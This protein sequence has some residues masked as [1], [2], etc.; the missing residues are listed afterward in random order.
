MN[1]SKIR[2]ALLCAGITAWPT[3]AWSQAATPAATAATDENVVTLPEFTIT[4]NPDNPYISR[5]ALSASRVAMDIQDI[6]QSV[7]VVT[8]DFL[9]DSMSHRMLDAAK[10][11]TTVVEGTLPIGGDRYNI[12]GFQVSQEFID[13]AQS[14]G[15]DGYSMSLVPY[16][17]E[18]IEI[19]KGPN[20]IL[21]PG[22]SPGGQFNPITKSPV[23]KDQGSVTL[24]LAQYFSNA[25]SV[26]VNRIISTEK[27]VATR[28]VAAYWNSEG[29][30]REHFRRGFMFAPSLAW[31]LSD[32]HKFIAKFEMMRNDEAQIGG[33]PLDPSVG[34]NDY[35]RPAPGLPRNWTFGDGNLDRR[36]RET[37]RLTLELLSTL[38]DHVSSRLQLIGNHVV[39]EDAGGTGAAI[40]GALSG[41]GWG[42]VNP[43]TG[44]WEPG[45][46]WSVNQ[47][48][49]NAVATATPVTI[50]DPST[51]VYQRS[52]GA[53]D[54]YYSEAHLRNDYAVKFEGETWRSTTIGGVAANF[55]KVQFKSYAN[56]TRPNVP[57]TALNNA[58][59]PAYNY[60]QPSLPVRNPVTGVATPNGG[61][62]TGEL[63]DLQLF[64]FESANLFRDRVILSGGL[65][66]YFGRLARTDN[67][68]IGVPGVDP[69]VAAGP[70]YPTYTLSTNAVSWGVV[71][72]PIKHVSLFYG[73]NTSGGAMPGQLNA[74]GH[75]PNF[76]T[77]V[78][79]QKEWGIKTSLLNDRFTA[80]FAHFD[81]AQSNY[82]VPNS[83]YYTLV[84][85]G[86]PVP[87]DFPVTL[88]LNQVSKG[89]EAEFTYAFNNNFTILGNV[90][91]LEARQA[92]GTRIRGTPDTSYAV[93][94]DYRFTSGP[95]KGFGFNVGVDYKSDVTG[96]NPSGF[97]TTKP[98]PGGKLVLNQH[99]FL[100]DERTLVNVGINY[101]AETWNAQVQVANVFDENYVLAAGSRTNVIMGDPLN[102]RGS[103][104]YKF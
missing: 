75:A 82:P 36:H 79:N 96:T 18:R 25:L 7:S 103:I 85:Q 102:V 68:F 91:D 73:Y 16:N 83:E 44:F 77:Q 98:L 11:V 64:I 21:V 37:E 10:Y 42:S 33:V 80:S 17:I 29:Y 46:L 1:G 28:L 81:I 66:R 12:R 67:T 3:A 27:G 84:A 49:A 90:T 51:F 94:A 88:Y 52:Y 53:V 71:V 89:W 41:P 65:S 23:M 9:R 57:A 13:G 4:E 38:S 97:T 14:S 99:Q 63:S 76:R 92:T 24:D 19:I 95:L 69:T 2:V 78:G 104:T 20:A 74:G 5:K 32:N 61:N 59:Y 100:V 58:T 43:N 34:S 62:R 30:L 26:D 35:A 50:P 48:G 87:A 55:S 6:P 54:L 31:Q 22:G 93:Y 47:T 15:A 101:R 56:Q 39:R 8:S 45:V 60:V 72:K 86:I 40:I 70:Y